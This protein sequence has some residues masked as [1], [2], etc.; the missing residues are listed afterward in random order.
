MTGFLITITLIGIAYLPP[1]R[2]RL[3]LLIAAHRA[4]NGTSS[5]DDL[6]AILAT[7]KRMPFGTKARILYATRNPHLV[8]TKDGA[9]IPTTD[10]SVEWTDPGGLTGQYTPTV[11]TRWLIGQH[12]TSLLLACFDAGL[13]EKELLDHVDGT[14]PVTFEQAEML[15]AFRT[16]NG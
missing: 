1:V 15:S 10:D 8:Y 6:Q 4:R 13:S 9:L 2:A 16:P 3:S 7:K 12:S 14:N 11:V 5:H